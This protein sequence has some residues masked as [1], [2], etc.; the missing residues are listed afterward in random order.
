MQ[1]APWWEF[2]CGVIGTVN[3]VSWA[4]RPGPLALTQLAVFEPKDGDLTPY[5]RSLV[6][7]VAPPGVHLIA[8]RE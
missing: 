2:P 8:E 4:P 6:A 7:V 3:V 1:R 5:C